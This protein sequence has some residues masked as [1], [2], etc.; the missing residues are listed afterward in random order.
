MAE[1]DPGIDPRYAA[2]FQRGYDGPLLV[3]PTTTSAAAA[4]HSTRTAPVRMEGGPP[5]TAARVPD[6]PHVVARPPADGEQ[7][8]VDEPEPEPWHVARPWIFEWALLAAGVVLLVVAAITFWLA[9][10]QINYY[11]QFPSDVSAFIDARNRLPGP[12]LVGGV[13][14]ISAWLGVRALRSTRSR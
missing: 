6:P 4:P 14:A 13:I 12:L 10:T 5:A 9:A 11:G 1:T 7:T 2:Q 8:D 3:P